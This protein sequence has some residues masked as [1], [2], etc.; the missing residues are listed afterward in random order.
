MSIGVE[1][2]A[3]IFVN[4]AP[5][6]FGSFL[7]KVIE[8]STDVS[9]EKK[10]NIFDKNNA[11]H[12]HISLWIRNLH[13][14]DE[15]DQW[16]SW[17]TDQQ[18]QYIAENINQ[19]N[20][21][22]RRVHR[23]TVPKYNYKFRH[24]FTNAQFIKITVDKNQIDLVAKNMSNKTFGHWIANKVTVPLKTILTRVSEEDQRKYYLGECRK[25]II[26]I[27]DNKLL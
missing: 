12:R 16:A 20:T 6:S 10:S 9:G 5:G 7:T 8:L 1:C 3:W 19:Q 13:D 27:V 2:T 17:P 18:G 15:I 14:G 26:N 4:Y 25:R 22:L 11:S 24:H 21:T 23:L